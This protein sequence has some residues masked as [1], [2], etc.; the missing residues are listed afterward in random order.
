MHNKAGLKSGLRSYWQM[1]RNFARTLKKYW[2]KPLRILPLS[3]EIIG[4]P[5]GFYVSTWDWVI[6]SEKNLDKIPERYQEIYPKSWVYR[7]EPKT[8]DDTIHWKF[9]QQYQRE[10]PD[11]F[12]VVIKEGRVWGEGGTV[13]TPD[14]RVLVDISKEI[15]RSNENH[16]I[17]SQWKLPSVE[18]I[19]GTVGLL[20]APLGQV[21]FHWMLNVL[22][23][24]DLLRKG[25]GSFDEIDKFLVNGISH[26]FERETLIHLGIPE[27]KII[28]SNRYPHIKAQTLLVP[29][30]PGKPGN[31]IP[32][33]TCEFLRK[34]FLDETL[35]EDSTRPERLYITR[36][37]ATHRR[38]IN[39]TE[40]VAYL[41]N[42]EFQ[43]VELESIP[44]SE[45]ILLFSLA[46][47]IVAPHGGGLTNVVFCKP[48]TKIIELFS[49]NYVNGCFWTISNHLGLDY[50]YAT[51]KGKTP[52]TNFDPHK[53]EEDIEIEL[54]SLKMLIEVVGLR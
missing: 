9:P 46:K 35:L 14:D 45:Q 27:S 28:E 51:G 16:S 18:K 1:L 31:V 34:E 8:V 19:D 15:G 42:H 3:S 30:I 50:Y 13:I 7:S 5:K 20:S 23:R 21:Y 2:G 47:V 22:P 38:V 25:P 29:S 4:P 26:P 24:L 49:P 53:I 43:T 40:I 41:K 10:A 6:K 12:V 17:F 39:E 33:W 37:K 36:S 48:G 52:P 32:L 54:S 44:L 11:A